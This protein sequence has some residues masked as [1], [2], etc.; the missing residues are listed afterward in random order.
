MLLKWITHDHVTSQYK[1]GIDDENP[2]SKVMQLLDEISELHTE[3]DENKEETGKENDTG[4][5]RLRDQALVIREASLVGKHTK[6]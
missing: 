6:A 3:H 5:K 2:P 1:S 4:K